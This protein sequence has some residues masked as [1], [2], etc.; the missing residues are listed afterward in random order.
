VEY[1]SPYKPLASGF[2]YEELGIVPK[3]VSAYK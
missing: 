2:D 1:E 3:P